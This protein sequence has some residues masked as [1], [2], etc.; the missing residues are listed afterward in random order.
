MYVCPRRLIE[1]KL[2]T[3]ILQKYAKKVKIVSKISHEFYKQTCTHDDR[4]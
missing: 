1:Q 2:N 3:I 4:R